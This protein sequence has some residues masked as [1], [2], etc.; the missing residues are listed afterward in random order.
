MIS[1]IFI[2]RP[3]LAFV[4]SIVITLAGILAIAAI[5]VAQFPDIVPPQVT[6][7]TLY[8]G[9]DAEVVEATVAQPIEQ[10]INGVDNALYY[11]SA[12]GAD[13]SYS[14]TVTFALGTDPDI[15]TVNVQNR[16]QLATPLLPQ[17]V[18]RQ[19]L[20]IRKKSAALLQVISIYSPKNTHDA[21]FL[22]NYATINIID[23][24][25]R[26]RGVGQASL[27]GPLDYSLRLWLDPDR[28]TAFNLT[29]ADV[30]AAVQSQNV[31]AA[32]GRIGAAPTPQRQQLQLTITTEGRLSRTDEFDN[33]IVRANPDGSVV[34]V[35]DVARVDLGAKTEERTGRYNGAPAALIG[36][37]QSPGANAVEV[38]RHV[39][40]SLDQLKQRFPDDVTYQVFWDST[41]FVTTTVAEVIRSLVIAFVLVAIVVFLFLGKL[42][43]TLIPLI[44]VP[45]SII[46]AFAVMLVIG[47]SANT[48]SLLALVLAI[49]IVV[50]DAIVVI[51]NVERVIEEEPELSI[52]AATKKAMAEITGPI[53]AITLVLLS[54]FVPV[55]FIPGISGQLFRQFAVA[56]STSMLISAINALTLSPALCS[57][58]LKRGRSRRGPM[59]YVLNAID[60][61]RDGYV[62]VVRRLVRVAVF[63]V[64]VVAGIAA[65]S[66]GLFRITPQGFLPAEDQGAFFA[67]MRLPEGASLNRTEELVAQVENIV[68][69]IP[70]VRGVISVV[71]LNFI[72]Y[73]AASNQAF[74]VVGMK[75]YEERTDPSQ[76]VDAIIARIRPQLAA[77][78]GAIVFPFNLPPILGLGNTGGF[79][80]ALEALQGQSP[81][82]IAAVM[83]GLLIAANQQP[84]LAAVFSTF[85]AD[86]PQI[87]LDI[88]RDK[89]QVLG[90]KVSDVF[91][92]LQSTLGGFYVNDFNLFGRTWQVNVQAESPFRDRIE[93]IYRVYVRGSGGAM[94]PIRALAQARLVQGPQAVI[95]Y[96]GFRGAIINGAP[97]PGYSSGQALAAM[98]RI[99]AAN[100]PAG[101]SFEW[102]G[103]ALQEKAASGQ[104]GIVLGLAVLFAYLFLVAL[105]ESWNIPISVLLSVT[106]AVLGAIGAVAWSGLAFDVYAQIGLVVLVALAAKNGILIV[107]FA[108]EQRRH[109]KTILESAVEGARLR[110]RPVMMTSFAFIF[111]LLPLV[112]ATG[113]G[114]LSRRAVG[115]PVFGGMIAGALFGVLVI[116]MLYVVFQWL[117]ER[118]ARRAVSPQAHAGTD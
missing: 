104:T 50:D 93:D 74:F 95:R 17:E 68:R 3:R 66:L 28:L 97:K 16:A 30:V 52:P 37:Y 105:Y 46:G 75:P 72:D 18:Q 112:I 73:V 79:Q 86:T 1:D 45:V 19:G 14:L 5:P 82:D 70:G 27:F 76:T 36:I 83:R 89:A 31:Q 64:V 101:Y 108:V 92:A 49:G 59:H 12:S 103:T 84:E 71:G 60:R 77:I 23:P 40:E 25:A 115:T 111:G 106:V 55:A 54:V 48:V 69:P 78:P 98:E 38:A 2:D 56:V 61:V 22:N 29:P 35:K 99:S 117:R 10:Q 67:A 8:P 53:I 9:A 57:V 87:R 109:G 32:L 80:Y 81:N 58:L 42:R 33:I 15:N 21:L 7:T 94:V 62:A 26:I 113:A 85:A 88:D 47:Y 91:N 34:R 96:N 39:R 90:V 24:L 63:G 110:F 107:E 43:T 114:A 20:L 41:V 44:A 65:A 100:L 11:Q 51:E 6:L 4:V 118:T 116:P 13:G 102:T